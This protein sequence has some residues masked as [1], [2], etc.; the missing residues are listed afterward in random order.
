MDASMSD[1]EITTYPGLDARISIIRLGETVDAV[2]VRTERFNVLVD[3]LDTPEACRRALDLLEGPVRDRPLVVVNSHMD[4]DH[5][6]GNAAVA[7]RAMIVAHETALQRYREP[8][9]REVLRQKAAEDARY[10]SVEL[11]GPSLTFCGAMRLDGGDLTLELLHTPGHTPDHVAVWIP[12]L[13]T[14]LAVDAVEDPIPEVWSDDPKDLQ[15][16]LRSLSLI[17]RLGAEHVVLAHG[18]TS[19]PAV[20][21]RNLA[22]FAELARRAKT[23]GWAQEPT[24]ALV[25]PAGLGLFEVTAEPPDL[26]PDARSFYETFHLSNLRAVIR[27]LREGVELP[28]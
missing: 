2:F 16:L 17:H 8:D 6:W 10:R 4:W 27:S 7:D 21:E 20:V 28:D 26:S 25:I 3:T 13:K 18:Q 11:H 1:V 12:E 5:F 22:Y 24:E 23:I 14:C 19:S 9:V 15:S